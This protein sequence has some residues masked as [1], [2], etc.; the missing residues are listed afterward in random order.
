M[1]LYLDRT[2][3]PERPVDDLQALR[4]ALA[5]LSRP[6][7][8]WVALRDAWGNLLRAEGQRDLMLCHRAVTSAG[9]S[10]SGLGTSATPGLQES[11]HLAGRTVK[12]ASTERL[13]LPTVTAAFEHF[14]H[15]GA[16]P[17]TLTPRRLSGDHGR[18]YMA[19]VG[20]A[21]PRPVIGWTD[22][23]RQLEALP[24]GPV[25]AA[26]SEPGRV[27]IGLFGADERVTLTLREYRGP[28]AW[29]RRLAREDAPRHPVE[30]PLPD[31]L[32]PRPADEV[33]SRADARLI[34]ESL[35]RFDAPPPG[36]T[37]RLGPA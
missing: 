27:F 25:L 17:E 35:Y 11:L 7:H 9:V 21:E 26:L 19:V 18:L 12:I 6:P 1:A 14:F 13:D 28:T 10:W 20:G 16:P 29:E 30:V 15:T 36:F 8:P 22:V 3:A 5:D 32:E 4:A 37:W 24:P 33:F 2:D 23:A 34:L 31:G